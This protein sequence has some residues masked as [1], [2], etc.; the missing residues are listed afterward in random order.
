MTF[1]GTPPTSQEIKAATTEIDPKTLKTLKDWSF[2]DVRWSD[3]EGSI[4]YGSV[5]I[6]QDDAESLFKRDGLIVS[7]ALF[8]MILELPIDRVEAVL[9]HNYQ[10]GGPFD[11]FEVYAYLDAE[12][13]KATAH[14]ATLPAGLVAGK[15]FS[16]GVADGYA[17]YI[18]TK[19]NPKTVK[20]EWRGFCPDRY[21]DR[22]LGWG[23]T[24]KRENIEHLVIADEKLAKVFAE[25]K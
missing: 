4:Q 10:T 8:P 12:Y 13:R 3:D 23:G 20:I 18:V 2:A 24:F 15:L 6:Y 11:A 22:V 25:A 1:R 16:V 5:Y 17:T 21:T 14:A 9:K 19:V 7:H